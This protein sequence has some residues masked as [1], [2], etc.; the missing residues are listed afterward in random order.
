MKNMYLRFLI[1]E[2]IE[3][4]GTD[5]E[6]FTGDRKTQIENAMK[7]Y[8]SMLDAQEKVKEISKENP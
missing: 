7:A 3:N 6:S 2:I 1:I 4:G 8:D 5:I